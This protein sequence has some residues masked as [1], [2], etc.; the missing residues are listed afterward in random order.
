MIYDVEKD[1]FS[2]G[3]LKNDKDAIKWCINDEWWIVG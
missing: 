3:H 2:T 1:S